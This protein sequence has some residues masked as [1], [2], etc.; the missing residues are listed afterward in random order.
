MVMTGE[1]TDNWSPLLRMINAGLTPNQAHG[2]G[3]VTNVGDININMQR[4][5]PP[6]QNVRT[7]AK[8]LRRALRR[9]IVSLE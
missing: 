1:A 6:D 3:N 4:D 8:S 9:G 7:F 2:G 5:A